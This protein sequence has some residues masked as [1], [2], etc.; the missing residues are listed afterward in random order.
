MRIEK[1][2][3][4]EN[5]RL[6]LQAFEDGTYFAEDIED[7]NT[8]FE[9]LYALVGE[10]NEVYAMAYL[11]HRPEDLLEVDLLTGRRDGTNGR[12]RNLFL[13]ELFRAFQDVRIVR[14]RKEEESTALT[15]LGFS[16]DGQGNMIWRKGQ[17]LG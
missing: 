6:D 13:A 8:Y 12:Y 1:F 5:Y 7:E 9:R 3:D 11:E 17:K 15:E 16:G 2:S 10:D 4:L 14:L